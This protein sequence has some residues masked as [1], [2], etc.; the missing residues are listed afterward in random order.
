M[1]V[2]IVNLDFGGVI[3]YICQLVGHPIPADPAGS[4]DLAVQQMGAAV[5]NAGAEML[6]LHEWQDLTNRA[7]IP[8]VADMAGQKEKAFPLPADFY[9]FIDQT[10][11]GT[12]SLLPAM[13]PV[14]PQ[15]WML[16]TV[17]SYNPQL[18]L[19][20]QIRNDKLNVL[21]P[22]FPTPV[23]FEFFYLSRA[24]IIDQDDPTLFKNIASK[25]GDKFF[26]DPYVIL[27]LARAKYLEWKGFDATGAM[28]DF[29]TA[30]NSRTG[31]DKGAGILSLNHHIGVP[32]INPM[33]SVPD[34]GYGS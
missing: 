27:L 13:G 6:A 24:Q 19:S 2:Q 10:Q 16:Y 12:Q 25:N 15:S 32:L 9:R 21:N 7:S 26:L 34:T 8:I 11:W 33:T 17:R 1:P 22:P 5:N 23:N 20:W 31:A 4:A 14:S 29:L 28:R 3:K 30:F 18:T